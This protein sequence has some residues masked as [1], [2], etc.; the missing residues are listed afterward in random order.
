MGTEFVCK[1]KNTRNFEVNNKKQTFSSFCT[2]YRQLSCS[3][4]EQERFANQK[5]GQGWEKTLA[6][7]FLTILHYFL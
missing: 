7:K 3:Y 6:G 4:G 2:E 5:L 1:V